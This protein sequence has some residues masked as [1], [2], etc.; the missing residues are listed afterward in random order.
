MKLSWH[1]PDTKFNLRQITDLS[2]KTKN[3]YSHRKG[4]KGFLMCE[5][6]NTKH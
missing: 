2:M 1:L 3:Y 4:R 6:E 5:L